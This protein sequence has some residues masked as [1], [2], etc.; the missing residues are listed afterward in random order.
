ML[1]IKKSKKIEV[2]L[3]FPS[4]VWL[5]LF[6]LVPSII[7]FAIAFR[8]SDPFGGIGNFW[9]LDSIKNLTIPNSP[10]IIFRTLWIST[11]NTMICLFLAVPTA[12]FMA[13]SHKKI[14]NTLL[15]F[16]V[17]PFW[18]N[19][20]IRTFAWKVFLHPEGIL[21]FVMVS[22][23]LIEPRVTFLYTPG[24]VLFV[25]VYSFLPFAIFPVYSAA[26]KFDFSLFEAAQD[27]GASSTIAF[28]KVFLPGIRK[29]LFTAFVMVFIPSL[30]S[31]I[32]PDLVGGTSA[33]MIGNKIAQ[34]TFV[35]RNL[36]HASALSALLTFI[37]ILPFMISYVFKKKENSCVKEGL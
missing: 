35:D 36:P 11:V 29:G 24:A 34:R 23:G 9:T 28:F 22:L 19:F 30:G 13:R 33:E 17:I 21:K 31:Y 5:L 8:S 10:E 12:Y 6:F 2:L 4:F 37:V 3:S 25:M 18:I 14:K 26:E 20:L 1:R 15:F 16:L 27:L 7:V 32:I